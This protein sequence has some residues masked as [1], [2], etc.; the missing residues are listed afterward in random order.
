MFGDYVCESN[1]S[2]G[3]SKRSIQLVNGTKPEQP[4]CFELRGFN[5][6]TFDLDVCTWR[7]IQYNSSM[8]ITGYQFEILSAEDYGSYGRKFIN[9]RVVL[10][11]FDE[12][13]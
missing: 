1:N 12:G 13:L 9:A 8:D 4:G 6:Q 3:T 11:D 5:S 7:V 2:L 10:K